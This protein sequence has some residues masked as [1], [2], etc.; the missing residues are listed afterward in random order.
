MECLSCHQSILPDSQFCNYC[1]ASQALKNGLLEVKKSVESKETAEEK[2]I[3]PEI[4][5]ELGSESISPGLIKGNDGVY[6]WAYEMSMWKSSPLPRTMAKVV[7]FASMVPTLLVT[8]LTLEEG[9]VKAAKVFFGVAGLVLSIMAV[10]FLLAY[11]AVSL[12]YGGTYCV[13]FEMDAKGVKHIQMQKQFKKG[14]VMSML[15]VLA[16]LATGNPQT[17]GAGLLAGARNTSY[18]S[19]PNVTS[20]KADPKINVI[21]VN[22]I[23]KKNQLYVSDEYFQTVFDHLTT[24]CNKAK[25]DCRR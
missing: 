16:G 9:I 15:T 12:V 19:F 7:F 2:N 24:Y 22:E 1:G 18:S 10:L 3:E 11:I 21:Y 5:R 14:Q 4:Y 8:F 23:A 6:R 25:V 13:A 17:A 20:I